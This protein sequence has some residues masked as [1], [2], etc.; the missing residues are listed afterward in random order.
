MLENL[1][2]V[3]PGLAS[4]FFIR[5]QPSPVSSATAGVPN[6]GGGSVLAGLAAV[7]VPEPWPG[8]GGETTTCRREANSGNTKIGWP[9]TPKGPIV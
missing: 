2:S 1:A 7:D 3:D 6:G 8:G 9:S 5:I 4:I